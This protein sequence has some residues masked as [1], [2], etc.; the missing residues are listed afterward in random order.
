EHIISDGSDTAAELGMA[1]S[2]HDPLLRGFPLVNITNYLSIGYA[3]NEP[4]QYFVTNWQW[5][6]KM[7]W[8]KAN[9]IVKFGA[10][11]NRYQFN[12]PYFNNS[13][14]TMTAN[15][16]WSGNGTA[17]NGNSIADMLLGLLNTSSI[18]TQTA[19]NYMRQSS[20]GVFINDDWKVTRR[21]T[22]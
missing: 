13:R 12:Q 7:T 4:V 14:G 3:A 9:H 6:G 16:I 15:G 19:R 17:A 18:T 22:L 11:Y 8:I 5:D 10:D 20:I 1:G 21:L 2:A